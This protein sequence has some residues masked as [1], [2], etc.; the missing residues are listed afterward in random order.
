MTRSAVQPGGVEEDVARRL[1][2]V[3]R[4]DPQVRSLVLVD[5]DGALE[6]A[7]DLD[8][9]ARAGRVRP[10]HG[11]V[12]V[13]KDNVDVSG[14][15]T[16]CS[17]LAHDGR[18]ADHDAPVVQRLRAAGAVVLGRANMDELA[19]GAS[20]A[21]SVHGPTRN[22]WDVARSPGGSSGGCSAAVAAGLADLA[23]GTDTGG[24]VREPASQCGVVGIAPSPGLVP[25]AGVVPFD[26][27]CDRVGPLAADITL[28][29]RALAVMAG[30]P[31]RPLELGRP[32]RTPDLARPL[33]IGVVRQLMGAPNTP[34]VLDVVEEAVI[35][36]A[37][38]GA[39]IVTVEVPD[40]QRALGAYL[41]LTSAGAV[42]WIEPWVATGRAGAEVVR[43]HELGRRV[44]AD[45]DRL[46]EAA[47]VR[48]RLRVQ[49]RAAL[50]RCDVL[51]SPTMPTTAP[52][53]P[54][55]GPADAQVADPARA[56]Y[57]DCW[58]VVA[59]LTGL[60]AVSVPGGLS[61]EDG[62]P[63]GV[64]LSGA[65]GSDALLLA[66]ASVAAVPLV[67]PPLP[68]GDRAGAA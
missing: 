9:A 28:T 46:E 18:P 17:S 26:P 51:L 22:P 8:R 3:E 14:Q 16:A 30:R 63:V 42:P 65:P 11:V 5:A 6:A 62:L 56:P 66:A 37:D 21:T 57:T 50:R 45:P 35:R 27:T 4:V 20:T 44:I 39:E 54:P 52:A 67:P 29:A 55:L 64:M 24:S 41:L 40:A 33:R 15:V 13:V 23:V 31:L 48:A 59:N 61:P 38:A 58:T 34:G 47:A 49:I 12:V 7:G 25:A 53:F 19:M 2:L 36:Q 43:R 60:P 32:L 1:A 68:V 10:L